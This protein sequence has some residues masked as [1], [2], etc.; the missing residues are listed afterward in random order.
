M[1]AR[2]PEEFPVAQNWG[3]G[4]TYWGNGQTYTCLPMSISFLFFSGFSTF[5]LNST[6]S[7][8]AAFLILGITDILNKTALC[9]HIL[10]TTW[11]YEQQDRWYCELWDVSLLPLESTN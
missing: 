7:S 9:D 10:V 8:E 2:F 1:I 11:R 5:V 3:N 4:Q 6:S